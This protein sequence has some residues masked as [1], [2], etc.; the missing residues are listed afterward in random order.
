MIPKNLK[1]ESGLFLTPVWMI[2]GGGHIDH[3]VWRRVIVPSDL[4]RS[5]GAICA[6]YCYNV[7]HRGITYMHAWFKSTQVEGNSC[8]TKLFGGLNYEKIQRYN[9]SPPYVTA[10]WPPQQTPLLNFLVWYTNLTFKFVRWKIG[11]SVFSVG[12]ELVLTK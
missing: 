2:R 7:I 3:H 1:G 6:Y 4:A 9:N 10:K 5:F 11:S 8:L 12:R